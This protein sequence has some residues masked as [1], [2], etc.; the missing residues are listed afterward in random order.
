MHSRDTPLFTYLVCKQSVHTLSHLLSV[1]EHFLMKLMGHLQPLLFPRSH[2]SPQPQVKEHS[3]CSEVALTSS[4]QFCRFGEGHEDCAPLSVAFSLSQLCFFS[5][6]TL[7]NTDHTPAD[8]QVRQILMQSLLTLFFLWDK[9]IHGLP[10]LNSIQLLCSLTHVC[11][12][13]HQ[14]SHEPGLVYQ[15]WKGK[16]LM[17]YFPFLAELLVIHRFWER[18]IMVF[19]C[20]SI[21]EPTMVKMHVCQSQGR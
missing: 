2:A 4:L 9:T 18:V 8:L 5:F 14:V 11:V 16:R 3:S 13:L 21:A 1:S 7:L 6:L 12:H 17:R 15:S 10:S 20:I 19:N